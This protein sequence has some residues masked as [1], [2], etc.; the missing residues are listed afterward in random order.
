M[1]MLDR[2]P[3]SELGEDATDEERMQQKGGPPAFPDTR[4]KRKAGT[5]IGHFYFGLSAKTKAMMDT[6]RKDLA[7]HAAQAAMEEADAAQKEMSG[8]SD[9]DRLKEKDSS[10]TI[11]KPTRKKKK[12]S[13]LAGIVSSSHKEKLTATQQFARHVRVQTKAALQLQRLFRRSRMPKMIRKRLRGHRAST[14]IG[15]NYRGYKGRLY[16]KELRRICEKASIKIEATWRMLC[17][18]RVFEEVKRVRTNAALRIQPIVRGWF[19]RQFVAWKRANDQLGT[20]MNKI[21]R[22]YLTRCRFKRMLAAHF[23]RT[24]VIPAVIVIQCMT[25]SSVARIELKHLRHEKWI[26]EVAI[27]AS[28]QIQKRIRGMIIREKF[29]IQALRQKSAILIQ[30]IARGKEKRMEY[31][32]VKVRALKMIKIVVLQRQG[33]KMLARILTQQR[34][35]KRYHLRIRIPACIKVQG[36]FRTHRAKKK[37]INIRRNVHAALKIQCFYRGVVGRRRMLVEWDKMRREYKDR[38][39]TRLQSEF[40]A[41]QARKK[42]YLLKQVWVAQRIAAATIIQAGW[43]GYFAFKNVQT[44]KLRRHAER[45]WTDLA[46]CEDE[47]VAIMDDMKDVTTERAFVRKSKKYHE[48]KVNGPN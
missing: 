36:R 33:R 18:K 8:Q 10:S 41:Y 37:I 11:T 27:P 9:L 23:H 29:R 19:G 21:V 20:T 2:K 6:H 14:N 17:G 47:D 13:T 32:H 34:R 48:K 40:R 30:R 42:F 5:R 24:V 3:P 43:K 28:I 31:V 44:K 38:L 1:R 15:R 45:I 22:G 26:L 4:G 46:W 12:K 35:E 7:K 39:A 25:R 16:Y